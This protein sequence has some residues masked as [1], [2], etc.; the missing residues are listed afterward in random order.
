[1]QRIGGGTTIAK[2]MAQVQSS[3]THE[4][5][6]RDAHEQDGPDH[7]GNHDEEQNYRMA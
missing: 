6:Y 5:R 3:G 1:M 2:V 7:L 4:V